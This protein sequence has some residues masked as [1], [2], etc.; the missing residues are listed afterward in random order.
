MTET[1]FYGTSAINKRRT[2]AELEVLDQAIIDAVAADHPVT[3]RGVYYRVMSA[4]VVDKTENA[5]KACSRRLL[6][7]RRNGRV[8]YSH[9]TD[10]TRWIFKP[11]TY[12]SADDALKA[13]AKAYTQ[14][15]WTNSDYELSL[16][17]EKDAITGTIR[18]VCE[19]H[20]VSLGVVR[21]YSSESFA[22]SVAQ[23]MKPWK[24]NVMGN[25]GDH[26]PS[27]VH[28]WEDFTNKVRKFAGPDIHI[29]TSRIAVTPEQI[30]ELDLPLRPTKQ[31]D[32]RSKGWEGGSVEVDAI[33]AP[34]L[35]QIVEEWINPFID[36]DDWNLLCEVEESE[37]T[38]LYA[39]MNHRQAS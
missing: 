1:S 24:V 38:I 14:A 10:G 25:M 39:L 33:P 16:Y 26:D 2:N 7:L 9:I 4:G 21:G 35:R 15:M 37:R 22:W 12:K 3:L 5:Y 29:R 17:S 36:V 8:P 19:L 6:E 27:G 30:E 20:D 18:S 28:A 32:S 13:T 11:D 23:S 34:K 31:T